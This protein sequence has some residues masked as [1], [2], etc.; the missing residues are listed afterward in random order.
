[1]SPEPSL[2]TFEGMSDQMLN[3]LLARFVIELMKRDGM[4]L[5]GSHSFVITGKLTLPDAP[6]KARLYWLET[7]PIEFL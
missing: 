6:D 3:D 1:M 2:G 7:N 5:T 4:E